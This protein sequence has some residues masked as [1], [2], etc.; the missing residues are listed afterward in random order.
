MG[1]AIKGILNPTDSNKHKSANLLAWKPVEYRGWAKASPSSFFDDGV[2]IDYGDFFKLPLLGCQNLK[3]TWAIRRSWSLNTTISGLP[4]RLC[5]ALAQ[6]IAQAQ[7]MLSPLPSFQRKL[8]HPCV[9]PP[10]SV[11]PA[12]LLT[13]FLPNTGCLWIIQPRTTLAK[14]SSLVFLHLLFDVPGSAT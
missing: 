5:S 6:L 11:S 13:N 4:L 1:D 12:L 7:A 2:E 8:R 10:Q 3:P 9:R 14:L